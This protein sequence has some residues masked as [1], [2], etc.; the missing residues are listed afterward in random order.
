M[1]Y[2]FEVAPEPISDEQIP[3]TLEADVIVVGAGTAGLVCAV[4]A[5]QEGLSVIVIAK[6]D[7]PS[8]QGGS[9]FAI[10]SSLCRELGVDLEVG[11][12]VTHEMHISAYRVSEAQWSIFANRSGEAMDWYVGL[13]EE[14]GLKATL[15]IPSYNCGGWTQE[16]EGSHIFYGGPNDSAFGDLPD[17][18]AVL[19]EN[20]TAGLGQQLLYDTCAQQ[21]VRDDNGRVSAVVAVDADGAYLKLVGRRAVVVATG[22]YGADDEMMSRYCT[23][24]RGLSSMKY[25]ANNTG[26]GHKMALWV[27][28]A[29]QKNDQH[30]AMVFGCMDIYRALIVNERGERVGNERISNAFNGM[31]Q[32]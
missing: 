14:G 15:E 12:A 28:A 4:S 27:D 10:N 29:M 30:A 21:L 8:G 9:H 2:G 7:A 17:K 16:Y 22:D 20:L 19:V 11:E 18:L 5:A 24:V 32:L 23:R 6:D 26:D 1:T 31:Q 3:Q 13:M 25:P